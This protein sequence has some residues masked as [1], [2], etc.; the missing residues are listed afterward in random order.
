MAESIGAAYQ[1]G[2]TVSIEQRPTNAGADYATSPG[3]QQAIAF[4]I[5]S[6]SLKI[7][8]APASAYD[9]AGICGEYNDTACGAKYRRVED[10]DGNEEWAAFVLAITEADDTTVDFTR[11]PP[12]GMIYLDTGDDRIRVKTAAADSDATKSITTA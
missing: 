1:R 5:V 10:D 12:G 11:F 2:P 7:Y 4:N 9:N 8:H 3:F 6:A